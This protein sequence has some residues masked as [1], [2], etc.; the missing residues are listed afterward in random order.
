MRLQTGL[1]VCG[2][3]ILPLVSS[4]PHS[5]PGSNRYRR[6]WAG[7][8]RRT[9]RTSSKNIL[10][11]LFPNRPR[12]KWPTAVE[13]YS[14][15]TADLDL[16]Q[17]ADAGFLQSADAGF[18]QAADLP[19]QAKG[20][21][22]NL[23]SQ[24]IPKDNNKTP[25]I[26][27]HIRSQDYKLQGSRYHHDP[28]D[29]DGSGYYHQSPSVLQEDDDSEVKGRVPRYNRAEEDVKESYVEELNDL[30]ELDFGQ[31]QSIGELRDIQSSNLKGNRGNTQGEGGRL[32]IT[33]N[34]D[35]L[36]NRLMKEIIRRRQSG[37]VVYQ[38]PVRSL[39]QLGDLG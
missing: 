25:G 27:S 35:V 29:H 13:D 4:L 10:D 11:V 33:N 2:V 1:T 26:S 16:R 32:S 14:A 19:Q 7:F 9:A 3:L 21:F 17:S 28:L 24:V 38:E 6:N 30:A 22:L 8:N 23:Q 20:Y 37:V 34:L 31:S 5:I 36:R 39:G 18:L 12:S 15:E